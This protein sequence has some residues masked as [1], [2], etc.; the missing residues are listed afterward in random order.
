MHEATAPLTD[1][2]PRGAAVLYE[3]QLLDRYRRVRVHYERRAR[4]ELQIRPAVAVTADP[5]RVRVA[6][7]RAGR[8]ACASSG[9]ACATA[10]LGS[11]LRNVVRN[12]SAAA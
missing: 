1:D 2:A 6:V 9:I 8:V 12:L 11:W 5:A 3:Q 4:Q 7:K 10:G